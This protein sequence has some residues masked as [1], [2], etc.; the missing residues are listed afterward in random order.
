MDLVRGSAWL[1][2]MVHTILGWQAVRRRRAAGPTLW[3]F[4]L[5]GRQEDWELQLTYRAE[6]C[7]TYRTFQTSVAQKSPVLP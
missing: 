5:G 3:V 2:A 6:G 4:H 1:G 7:R